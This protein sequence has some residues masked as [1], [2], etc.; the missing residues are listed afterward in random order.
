MRTKRHKTRLEVVLIKNFKAKESKR[1]IDE[2]AI[3]KND[4]GFVFLCPY[5]IICVDV[6][7]NFY[8]LAKATLCNRP[9]YFKKVTCNSN[10]ITI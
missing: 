7:S 4:S 8:S 3:E 1:N 5:I 6:L 10:V 2:L 9:K